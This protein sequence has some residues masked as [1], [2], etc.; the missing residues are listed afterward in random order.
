MSLSNA[1]RVEL[2]QDELA[3]DTVNEEKPAL[4]EKQRLESVTEFDRLDCLW[5]AYQPKFA[6]SMTAWQRKIAHEEYKR[7]MANANVGAQ[8]RATKKVSL[9]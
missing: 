4:T 9:P 7:R 2:L 3:K 1:E 8:E 5:K 6:H